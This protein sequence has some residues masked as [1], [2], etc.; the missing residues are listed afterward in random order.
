MGLPHP[1]SLSVAGQSESITPRVGKEP[2]KTD[3]S[4]QHCVPGSSITSPSSLPP[5]RPHPTG[6]PPWDPL[7]PSLASAATP[8]ISDVHRPLGR[9]IG[10]GEAAFPSSAMLFS[11]RWQGPGVPPTLGHSWDAFHRPSQD[12]LTAPGRSMNSRH[13]ETFAVARVKLAGLLAL[14]KNFFFL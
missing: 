6:I 7:T 14:K 9:P 2:L 4:C 13:K 10:C 5:P 11:R 1:L 3:A 8:N 12:H